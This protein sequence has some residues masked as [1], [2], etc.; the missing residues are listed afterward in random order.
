[1]KVILD[2]LAWALVEHHVLFTYFRMP[3]QI[4]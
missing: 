4:N 3:I 2:G 1:M